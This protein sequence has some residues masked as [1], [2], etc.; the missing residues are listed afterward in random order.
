MTDTQRALLDALTKA[1]GHGS[2]LVAMEVVGPVLAKLD[3]EVEAAK[4][5]N[6]HTCAAAQ[7]LGDLTSGALVD[8]AQLARRDAEIGRLRKLGLDL[9]AKRD[10][11]IERLWDR[12]HKAGSLAREALQVWKPEH[13][14]RQERAD[15][16]G[17]AHDEAAAK[18]YGDAIEALTSILAALNQP[19]Q[20]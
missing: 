19:E 17:Y 8:S 2:A 13:E 10:A 3:D 5:H 14:Y 20:T 4:A 12:I 16:K 1:V 7:A 9:V 6:D 15:R 18:V 11:E